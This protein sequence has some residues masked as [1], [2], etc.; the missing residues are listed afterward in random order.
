MGNA[1]PIDIDDIWQRIERKVRVSP[2]GCWE[3]TGHITPGGYGSFR[4]IDTYATHRAAYWYHVGD[5]PDGTE[6][7][8][9]CRNRAC[10]NPDHLEAVV[11]QENVRR[12]LRGAMTD[13]ARGH[14]LTEENTYTQSNG[15]RECRICRRERKRRYRQRNIASRST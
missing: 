14:Q 5:I 9:L 3:Y 12:G 10:C 11:H 6:I 13:C 15:S 7:D 2:S 8:H 1:T 4:W